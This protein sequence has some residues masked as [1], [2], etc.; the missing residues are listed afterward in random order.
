MRIKKHFV[1]TVVGVL[2][3]SIMSVGASAYTSADY[4]NDWNSTLRYSPGMPTSSEC[5]STTCS[6]VTSKAG[7]TLEIHTTTFN[8]NSN[9]VYVHASCP[10]GLQTVDIYGVCTSN[11][12]LPSSVKKGTWKTVSLSL[13]AYTGRSITAFGYVTN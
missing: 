1:S 2:A 6:V 10:Q 8:A 4:T 11:I 9:Y 12:S 7:S 13:G 5:L 3:A